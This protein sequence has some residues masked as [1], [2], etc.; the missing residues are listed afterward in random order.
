MELLELVEVDEL[1]SIEAFD[2]FSGLASYE[3]TEAWSVLIADD[4]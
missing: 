3:E 2:E 4:S 1:F